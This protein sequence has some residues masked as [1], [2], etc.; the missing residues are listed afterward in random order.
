MTFAGGDTGWERVGF[1][2][3]PPPAKIIP[4]EEEGSKIGRL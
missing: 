2:T 4:K 1:I 3:L